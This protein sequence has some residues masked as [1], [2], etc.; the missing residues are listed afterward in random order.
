MS[1]KRQMN[2]NLHVL[3]G[4]ARKV[5]G[6]FRGVPF[7]HANP[8]MAETCEVF[9]AVSKSDMCHDVSFACYY[10]GTLACAYHEGCGTKVELESNGVFEL[11]VESVPHNAQTTGTSGN[12][13]LNSSLSELDQIQVMMCTIANS[14]YLRCLQRARQ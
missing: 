5:K 9:V 2:D 1:E 10:K 11:P 6:K 14:E 13:G 7:W 12:A 4:S 8:R 3:S